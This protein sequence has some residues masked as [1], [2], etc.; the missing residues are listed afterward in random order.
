MSTAPVRLVNCTL[1]PVHVRINGERVA[2][3]QLPAATIVD[4]TVDRHADTLNITVD[5]EHSTTVSVRDGDVGLTIGL[6]PVTD[7]V[8]YLVDAETLLRSPHRDDFVT[9]DSYDLDLEDPDADFGAVL[10]SVRRALAPVNADTHELDLSTVAAHVRDTH[11]A[12]SVSLRN[13]I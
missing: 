3:P 4:S 11:L 5:G 8:V 6:P 10:I 7:G 13:S 1:E 12:A 2:L 9:G